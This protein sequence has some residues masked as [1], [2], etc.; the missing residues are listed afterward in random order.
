[1][2]VSDPVAIVAI[3]ASA[4]MAT[5]VAVVALIYGRRAHLHFGRDGVEVETDAPPDNHRA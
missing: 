3:V 5:I 4:V 1:M 2:I